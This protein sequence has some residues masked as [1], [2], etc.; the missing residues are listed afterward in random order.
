MGF[1]TV[2]I[3]QKHLNKMLK[4]VGKK[5]LRFGGWAGAEQNRMQ[6]RVTMWNEVG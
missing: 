5:K 4:L 1:V 3:W 6:V 2:C